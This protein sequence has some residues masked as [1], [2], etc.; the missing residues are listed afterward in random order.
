MIAQRM[1]TST[2]FALLVANTFVATY[3]LF[4]FSTLAVHIATQIVTG[5]SGGRPLPLKY[6]QVL[7]HQTWSSYT[8]GAFGTAALGTMVNFAVAGYVTE[9]N[10]KVVASAAVFLGVVVS[11]AV[12]MAGVLEYAY[13]WRVLRQAAGD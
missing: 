13:Y 4:H 12:M 10:L 6:R 3:L 2:A 7:L 11:F 9:G 8:L 1:S 5:V